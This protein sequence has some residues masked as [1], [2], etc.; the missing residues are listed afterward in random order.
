MILKKFKTAYCKQKEALCLLN[1]TPLE[2][3][4]IVIG[5]GNGSIPEISEDTTTLVNQRLELAIEVDKSQLPKYKFI[6]NIPAEVE[7]FQIREMG[8]I[9][10]DGKLLY[11]TQMEGMSTTLLNS[12]ISKQIRLQMQFTPAEGVNIIVIDPTAATASTD[13]VDNKIDSVVGT[14]IAEIITKLAN[15]ASV[16]LDNL[17]ATAQAM[18]DKKVEIEALLEQNG[19]AKFTWKDGNKI[20]KLIVQFGKVSNKTQYINL[21]TSYSN[22]NYSIVCGVINGS[23]GMATGSK[24][25][26]STKPKTLSSF[27]LY[28]NGASGASC[29]GSYWFTIGY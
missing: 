12:G 17:S 23:G 13:Y 3:S 6:A 28:A 8:I 2:V 4:K 5:D 22:V 15:Y 29:T 27:Y 11:V 21:P 1:G 18:L 14:N 26:D 7:E 20:S 16:N 24:E 19:Y 25:N 9:D 10:K